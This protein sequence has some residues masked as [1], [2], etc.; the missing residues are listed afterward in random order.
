MSF[1]STLL[2]PWG[3]IMMIANLAVKEIGIFYAYI[4]RLFMNA[5]TM[6][7]QKYWIMESENNKS[8][9]FLQHRRCLQSTSFICSFV[10][11]FSF[12]L[13]DTTTVHV[14]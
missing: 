14:K 13:L 10:I 1:I 11:F 3:T 9:I 7:T 4:C 5:T 2:L 8:T 6:Y 12:I